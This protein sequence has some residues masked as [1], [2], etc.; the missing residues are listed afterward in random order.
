MIFHS[1]CRRY[2][3]GLLDEVPDF[4]IIFKFCLSQSTQSQRESNEKYLRF[5]YKNEADFYSGKIFRDKDLSVGWWDWGL[6]GSN[7]YLP[8]MS[9]YLYLIS[10]S[11]YELYNIQYNWQAHKKQMLKSNFEYGSWKSFKIWVD[12]F[13]FGGVFLILT[14]LIVRENK[15]SALR[16]YILYK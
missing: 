8:G 15:P 10:L 9:G 1:L 6:S 7:V 11:I 4:P 14:P 5:G 2:E 16:T 3:M 13:I 12:N